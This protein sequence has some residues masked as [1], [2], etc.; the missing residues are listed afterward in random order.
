MSCSQGRTKP[1]VRLQAAHTESMTRFTSTST[2]TTVAS[3]APE[4][5]AEEG[6]GG[7][8][9]QFEEVARPISAPGAATRIREPIAISS[10]R[11]RATS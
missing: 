9:G 8:H 1:R 11:M 6:Y 5:R 2:P 4:P 3:A 10:D 7:R